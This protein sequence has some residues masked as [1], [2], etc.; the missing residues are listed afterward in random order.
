MGL[1]FFQSDTIQ[2][3]IQLTLAA[4]LGMLIGSE[5]EYR[6]KAAGLRTYML[7]ALGSALF[8]VLSSQALLGDSSLQIHDPTR[9]AAQIV[10]G[11]GFLGAGL[12]IFHRGHVEGLT[13]AA[14]LWTTAAIGMAV[15]FGFYTISIYTTVLVLVVLWALRYLDQQIHEV[16]EED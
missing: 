7:V 3:L 2:I 9:I 13:T 15:G 5:R 11:I 10:V 4:A 12:I 8:T 14:G 1:E 6:G 16:S